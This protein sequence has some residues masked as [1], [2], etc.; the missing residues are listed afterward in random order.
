M[1]SKTEISEVEIPNSSRF[2]YIALHAYSFHINSDQ[3]FCSSDVTA[4]SSS[5]DKV[6]I[7]GYLQKYQNGSWIN[8]K[9]WTNYDN[10]NYVQTGGSWYIDKGYSYRYVSYAYVYNNGVML[11]SD[12]II[13]PVSYY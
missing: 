5:V 8:I 2:T 9:Y 11:E 1:A 6:R 3:A 7:K 4:Y 10:G 13:S 12:S